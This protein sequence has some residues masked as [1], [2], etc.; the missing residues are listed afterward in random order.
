MN[1]ASSIKNGSDIIRKAAS[2]MPDSSGIYKMIAESG[3]VLYVGKAKSLPK[4]VVSY[5]NYMKLPNRLQRMVSQVHKVEYL[6]TTSED[7][8]LLLEANIIKDLRPP[9][10]INLKDDKTFPYICFEKGHEYPRIAKYRGNKADKGDYYGPFASASNVKATMVELQKV[11]RIRPCTDPYFASRARPCIQYEIKRCSAPCVGRI[12]KEDYAKSIGMAKEFLKGNNTEVQKVIV[13]SMEAAS[14]KLDFERAAEWRDRL[15][16]LSAIQ[17]KN[18]F[19]DS[20]S[21]DADFIISVMDHNTLC[22]QVYFIRGSKNYGNK[23]YFLDITEDTSEQEM[24]SDFVLEFYRTHTPP[25]LIMLSTQA[26]P[27]L[28]EAISAITNIKTKVI[29][30]T[31]KKHKDLIEFASQ[32]AKE[33]LDKRMRDHASSVVSLKEV[34]KLF[35]LHTELN[36]IEVY[37]NSHI[38]G[39]D[40]VGCMV[41]YNKNGFDKNEY[42]I[43]NIHS[44]NEADDYEML[45]EVLKRRIKNMTVDNTPDLMLI[46]GGKGH[47]STALDALKELGREDLNIVCISKGPD[48]NAGREYFH[49][50]NKEAFQ[51]PMK[52]PVLHFLQI[53]RDE[54]HRY[55]ITSHRKKRMKNIRR[56]NLDIIPGVGAKRKKALLQY[57]GSY[58]GVLSASVNDLSRVDGISKSMADSIFNYLH[59]TVSK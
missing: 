36:R 45:R 16:A 4:R 38:S 51:L 52:D 17:A 9:Y 5:S 42:R 53:L 11:F 26:H 2:E 22:V 18:A 50:K 54:V 23:T 41:V 39:T 12:S 27:A 25:K 43:F 31:A 3:K 32:N 34:Q 49:M 10:N 15:K 57:F 29:T 8:A 48:R 1:N 13:S 33:I 20:D 46:D 19:F 55:A 44:T 56:S 28:E 21:K 59:S 24:V 6:I 47:L 14:E 35:D 37:D 58:D 40:A 7:E 30:A